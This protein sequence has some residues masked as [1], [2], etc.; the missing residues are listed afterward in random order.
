MSAPE[1]G[2]EL[3]RAIE[4]VFA[5]LERKQAGLPPVAASGAGGHL[6]DHNTIV[7]ALTNLNERVLSQDA[8]ILNLDK[9]AR[10]LRLRLNQTQV[11]LI[12][13]TVMFTAYLAAVA[14]HL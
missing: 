7:G 5:E 6:E 13:I 10:Q 14:F 9:R 11:V 8:Q 1:P 3:E 4:D 2:K 12:V